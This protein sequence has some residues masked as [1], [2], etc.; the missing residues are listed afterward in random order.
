MYR[1]LSLVARRNEMGSVPQQIAALTRQ[2]L[3]ER[4]IPEIRRLMPWLNNGLRV[5]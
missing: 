2:I 3:Q 5:D 4:S 1:K